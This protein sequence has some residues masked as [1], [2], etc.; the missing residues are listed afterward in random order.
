MYRFVFFIAGIALSLHATRSYA[1]D[2]PQASRPN[3]LII[4]GDDQ[5]SIDMGCFGVD[6]LKTPNMDRLA[7]Q[8]LRL[9]KMYSAAPV[10][11]ASRVGL[12]TGRYPARAG[13][14]GNGDLR[15][16]EITIAETFAKAGYHTGHVGKWHLGRETNTNPSGQ[17]FQ[18]WFGHLEGCIDN[19]SH[20]FFWAG[21]NRHDLWDNGKEIQR[22]GEYF[23][24]LMVDRCKSFIDQKGKE[25]WLLYWA[26]NAPHYPYQGSAKWLAHYKD[27]PTPR[28][29]YCAFTSTMDE[30]IGEVLD[31]LDEQGLAENTIVIYQP[32]HG[33]STETR[34]FGGGGNAGPYRG[35]KF[36]LF[37]GGIRVP[38]VVRYP[39]R[40]PAGET[41]T[42]FVTACDWFPT[43]C[44]WCDVALPKNQLDGVSIVDVLQDNAD[45]PR[46]QFYW[47]MGSGNGAQWAVRDQQW[48]L[49]GN[50]RDT[51]LPQSKQIAGGKLKDPLYLVDLQADPSEQTNVADQHPEIVKRLQTIK[52]QLQDGF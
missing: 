17:G 23:P 30:Y 16:D 2:P 44:Q 12:L 4:Y 11:S 37:E 3:V 36:S 7:S 38:S 25:P 29:E 49:I 27:L 51:T 19:Y 31:Y 21:P 47:Q 10:C 20:F 42:Q 14:P 33:H 22:G 43:L 35:A 28:R 32:D 15:A 40:L 34:A 39:G 24:R 46:E 1:A 9:T 52:D 13:Q 26:F 18:S 45:A 5:G 48:K 8:G 50:P 41:R 6:D